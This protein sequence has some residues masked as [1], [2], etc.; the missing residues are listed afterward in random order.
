M[1]TNEIQKNKNSLIFLSK[2]VCLECLSDTTLHALP[3]INKSSNHFG[4]K[5]I[6]V[7]SLLACG[8]YCLYS[9]IQ[10]IE[11]YYSFEYLTKIQLVQ[12]IPSE[13]PAVTFCNLKLLNR[14]N[15][16]TQNYINKSIYMSQA[17]TYQEIKFALAYDLNLTKSA[18]KEL[19]FKIEDMFL[20]G[21]GNKNC[22]FDNYPC[23]ENDFTYFFHP[24]YGNCYS[25]NI[26]YYE[27]GT[28]YE[29]KKV[30]LSS[31]NNGL[32]IEFFLGDP[33]VDTSQEDS[34]G[35]VVSIHNQSI[36]PFTQGSSVLA[37][38]GAYTRII[39]E[40]NY[41]KKL[42]QPYGTCQDDVSSTSAIKSNYFDYIV[43]TLKVEY[44]QEY[45]YSLCLQN[46]TIKYVGC[47]SVYLPIYLNT[48]LFCSFLN[49]SEWPKMW[50]VGKLY[51]EEFRDHCK[52]SC[53]FECNSIEYSISTNQALYPTVSRLDQLLNKENYKNRITNNQSAS[54]AFAK[55]NIYYKGMYYTT[56]NEVPLIQLEDL[57]SNLG[58]I[59]GL[60]L[61]KMNYK[62]GIKIN[63]Y[64]NRN[65]Y[66]KFS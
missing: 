62:M 51:G 31:E 22:L 58:G 7:I 34:D 59:L 10:A 32:A 60:F 49:N 45:C 17:K 29:T 3:N 21:Y 25:F 63:F 23:N 11:N 38:S 44:T 9:C 48:T 30:S 24:V 50:N 15:S 42:S 33:S 46:Q 52:E 54:Q 65:E 26:G 37:M 5:V 47:S 39:V 16:F 40:R 19:G 56:T 43:N 53:P 8:G 12:E 41:V 4:L 2:R 55:V 36:T 1:E 13:F 18:K 20:P 27:N 64:F 35:L 6:W 28:K 66:F 14:S 57:I 61:G